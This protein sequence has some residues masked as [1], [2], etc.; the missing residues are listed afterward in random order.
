MM[1]R[2]I[3][4]I[5]WTFLQRTWMY[6]RK[7][8]KDLKRLISW[9][10]WRQNC[11]VRWKI[12]VKNSVNTKWELGRFWLLYQ[13]SD[14]ICSTCTYV[15]Q[16]HSTQWPSSSYKLVSNPKQAVSPYSQL[17]RPAPSSEEGCYLRLYSI[18]HTLL[19]VRGLFRL[20]FFN[21]WNDWQ[22]Q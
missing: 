22:I 15:H 2:L 19:L 9:K 13:L 18:V 10:H 7:S 1:L 16:E 17:I 8:K 4:A 3:M 20:A 12:S 6:S 5:I 14:W 21:D 11:P